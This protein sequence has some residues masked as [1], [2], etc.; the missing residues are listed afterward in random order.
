[1]EQT[2]YKNIV[3]SALAYKKM[4]LDDVGRRFL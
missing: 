1:M 3:V 2:V 4:L